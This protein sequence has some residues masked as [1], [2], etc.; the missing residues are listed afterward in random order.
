MTIIDIIEKKRDG[1]ALS[2]DEI[3]FFVNN[4][5]NGIIPDYQASSLLMAIYLNGM[6]AEETFLLTKAMAESGDTLDLS[7]IPGTKV[8][9]HSSGGVG[10]KTTLVVAPA[11]ASLGLTVAKMSGRGLGFSGGTIDKLESIPGF[12]T[13]L[14][15]NEF[16]DIVKKSGISI[17]AATKNV[18]PA[19]KKLYALRD[20]TGTVGNISLIAS[21]IMSK[22]LAS[23]SDAIVLDVK[24]GSGA[25]MKTIDESIKLAE[26]LVSIGTRSGKTTI[27]AVTNM[28]QPLGNTVGNSLEVEEAI[29]TL[30]GKKKGDFYQLCRIITSL[31][32]VAGKKYST[33]KEAEKAFDRTIENGDAYIKFM[34][35]VRAQGGNCEA[36]QNTELLPHALNTYQI[37]AAKSG[38]I[39]SI[40]AESFGKAAIMIGAGRTKKTDILDLSAGIT[41]N[42]K[43][44]DA[45]DKGDLL[46]EIHYNDRESIYDA[47]DVLRKAYTVSESADKQEML[48]AIVDKKGVHYGDE[49]SFGL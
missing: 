21:S 30:K 11:A 17:I 37:K 41:L 3:C 44:G 23:N 28:D 47:A 16:T 15:E 20:V 24:T 14:S 8:D 33:L 6:N 32:L 45:V 10:D 25:F 38:V 7:D 39:S 40:D 46:A 18:A 1:H 13:D 31:M 29:E 48:F 42:K 26:E 2:K 9:K 19:D 49:D 4:Y 22:K 43:I 34:S 36:I 27:A 5:T 12:R 35:L